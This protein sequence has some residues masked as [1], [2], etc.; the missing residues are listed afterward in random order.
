MP[1]PLDAPVLM[2]D[3]ASIHLVD[4]RNV[5]SLHS[6][7]TVFSRCAQSLEDGR[8]L[9]NLSWRLWNQETFCRE[10]TADMVKM[11]AATT[12]NKS[13]VTFPTPRHITST[14]LEKMVMTIKERKSI[15]P[16]SFKPKPI[17]APPTP[18]KSPQLAVPTPKPI[19]EKSS[20][21]TTSVV[22]GFSPVMITSP[23]H[24]ISG[25]SS[26]PTADISAA[27]PSQA[28]QQ[29]KRTI[30]AL[31]GS[32]GDDSCEP[33]LST[34][35]LTL[36]QLPQAQQKKKNAVFS[37]GSSSHEDEGP[38][39]PVREDAL[40]KISSIRKSTT[41]QEEVA[42]RTIREETLDDNVFESDDDDLDESAIDD[43]DDSSDW[44]DS[45]EGSGE[46]S[47]DEKIS[48]AALTLDQILPH[49]RREGL[50]NAAMNSNSK[51]AS[52]LHHGQTETIRTSP[53]AASP[54]QT[55]GAI[56]EVPRSMAR[57]IVRP[58]NHPQQLA[59]SP[60]TTR[61]NMLASELTVS[62]RQHLLWERK[63]KSQTANAVLKRR[64]TAQDVV[65]LRQY[66]E[67][68]C[69]GPDESKGSWDSEMYGGGLGEY[70]SR[71]W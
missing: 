21:S 67:A 47:A 18:A 3:V 53:L 57:P 9:E 40:P 29:K 68:V 51:S 56:A 38:L 58:P 27:A 46:A 22:R 43:E 42:R 65:K 45:V 11:V 36:E 33:I 34:R 48:S 16:L 59:L 50:V 70:N 71:G 32:S 20:H 69:F 35:D 37:F 30:F 54:E 49:D 7:W 13:K 31:G 14:N 66:P 39:M 25:P 41:F 17:I 61:R 1:I 62:L 26:I 6:M 63:Q 12:T 64:H 15:Q 60:R 55:L 24:Y 44:E 10:S 5:E 2:V 19:I 4:T 28:S 23:S 52:T 8:R